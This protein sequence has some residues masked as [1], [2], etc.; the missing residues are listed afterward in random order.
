MLQKNYNITS[1]QIKYNNNDNRDG[2]VCGK[3]RERE[4]VSLSPRYKWRAPNGHL[5]VSGGNQRQSLGLT[6]RLILD[7]GRN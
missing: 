3:R 6:I 1:G 7:R 2:V 5:V 4:T